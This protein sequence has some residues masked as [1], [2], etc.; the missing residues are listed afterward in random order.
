MA[1]K[2]TII[3]NPF[4]GTSSKQNIESEL[5][6][7]NKDFFDLNFKH[8]LHS[9]HASDLVNEAIEE[10]SEIIVALGGDGTVNEV[11]S[12]VYDSDKD[13][14]LGILPGGSGNGFAM[15]LGLGRDVHKA[16]DMLKKMKY[17][18]VD[19]CDVNGRFFINVSGVGFDARI[20]YMTKKSASRGFKRYFFSTLNE[21]KNFRTL[22]MQ[23]QIDDKEMI[24]GKFGLSIIAN[25][26]MFG[27][28][29]TVS[30]NASI[31]DGLLDL[32]V[33]KE[34]S[35]FK[36]MLESYRMLNKTIDKSPLVSNYQGKKIVINCLENDYF[37]IDGE[38]FE[39]NHSLIYS[40]RPKQMKIISADGISI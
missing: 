17:Q 20:A 36:Y 35:A 34:A 23:I 2:V 13:I 27:Y 21:L 7:K 29:F 1:K 40:I 6:L 33:F 24:E 26:T 5:Q 4:S 11:A 18:K 39:L 16:F 28:N 9:G 8:T 14:Y 22:P 10:G 15:H 3:L 37:H 19:A 38:G 25:A 12:A 32:T 30:P 31:N